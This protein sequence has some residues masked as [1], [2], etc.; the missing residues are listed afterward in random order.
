MKSLTKTMA[1]HGMPR[2][3]AGDF[4]RA[5]QV[6]VAAG[7][8]TKTKA[9]LAELVKAQADHDEAQT[10]AQKAEAAAKKRESAAQ[11]AEAAA[12]RARQALVDDTATAHAE[13]GK[14]E[15]GVGGRE[16]L[17]TEIEATQDARDKGLAKREDHL[18]KAGVVLP[19]G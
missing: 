19:N 11:K 2:A 12:T 7:G 1:G 5:W 14:R 9:Y 6:I 13:L 3:K 8:D 4:E 17:A 15:A 10:A 18:R 16:G